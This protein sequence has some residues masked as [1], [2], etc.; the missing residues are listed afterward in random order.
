MRG[1]LLISSAGMSGAQ[2]GWGALPDAGIDLW[3]RT[4]LADGSREGP[5]LSM[6]VTLGPAAQTYRLPPVKALLLLL[7]LCQSLQREAFALVQLAE[8]GIP[9]SPRAPPTPP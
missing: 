1:Q 8:K 7:L 2:C 5:P 6:C 4:V 3:G 9:R